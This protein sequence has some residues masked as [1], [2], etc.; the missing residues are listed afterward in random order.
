MISLNEQLNDALKRE[1]T[2]LEFL[3]ILKKCVDWDDN[4]ELDVLKF[5]L[6]QLIKDAKI[7]FDDFIF[8]STGLIIFLINE[9]EVH[10]GVGAD[11]FI[12]DMIFEL[13]NKIKEIQ[14]TLGE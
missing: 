1:Q 11:S 13:K 5:K 8:F 4:Q 12:E 14:S 10:C 2:A 6:L 3:K 9:E 7:G